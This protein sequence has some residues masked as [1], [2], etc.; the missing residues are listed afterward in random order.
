MGMTRG[1]LSSM[2]ALMAF[3]LAFVLLGSAF[4][5]AGSLSGS[6]ADRINLYAFS[7][8]YLKTMDQSGV[9]G[10]AIQ[11][12][13]A[14]LLSTELNKSPY[15]Y[16]LALSLYPETDSNASTLSTTK[17]GCEGFPDDKVVSYRGVAV[18]GNG[19]ANFFV[20]GLEAWFHA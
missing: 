13:N 8:A 4:F 9:L 5:Y 20:A 12:Q 3:A 16:C 17:S 7:A 6:Q 10:K 11:T 1:V 15:K 19:D 2:D 14:S 18:T